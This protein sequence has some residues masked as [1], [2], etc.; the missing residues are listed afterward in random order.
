MKTTVEIILGTRPL[1]VLSA[2]EL[3]DFIKASEANLNTML[4]DPR[5]PPVDKAILE[6]IMKQP[7]EAAEL[8]KILRN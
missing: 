1:I 7:I 2:V 3:R 6:T 5:V 4:A 8:E